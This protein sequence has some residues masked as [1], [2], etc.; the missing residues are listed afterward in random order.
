MKGYGQTPP[1]VTWPNGKRLAV[2][3]VLNYEEGGENCV[4]HGDAGSEMFLS[5]IVG[6][7]SVEGARNMSMESL[8]EYGSRVGVWR[9]L[10]LFRKHKI[11]LTMFAVATALE[12][13]PL[14]AEIALKDGH[15]I[16]SHGYK[17]INY[18]HVPE[19]I[20]AEHMAKAIEIIKS[21]TGT[22]PYGWY[23]GR[24]SPNTRRL[25]AAEGGF[26][27][28][29]DDYSDDL[30]FW[31]R[32]E[33]KDHLIVPYTL[34]TNDM[35]FLTPQGFSTGEQFYTYLMDSF[36]TLYD[37]A[38]TAP[39][40]MSIGLHCRIIGKPGRFQALKKFLE[41]VATHDD[42]WLATRLDI[43]KHWRTNH[44]ATGDA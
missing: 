33:D 39:K 21:I 42:V 40:M 3:F 23:T 30:P 4:L 14:V 11:P 35:R 25:V 9:I 12:R 41:Y 24:T 43:A 17:W 16:C 34:D 36:Y 26:L 6:A 5:E 10:D 32:V 1:K 38:S 18:Q 19:D 22:R 29:A 27:Y 20:E 7:S 8:Y 28:D 44:P 37:E 2:Q 13:N 31:S 15:E